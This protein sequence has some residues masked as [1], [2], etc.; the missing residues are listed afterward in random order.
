MRSLDHCLFT[1][2]VEELKVD[3]SFQV[4]TVWGLKVTIWGRTYIFS[5]KI[6]FLEES[7]LPVPLSGCPGTGRIVGVS[8]VLTYLHWWPLDKTLLL[9]SNPEFL[10]PLFELVCGEDGIMTCMLVHLYVFTSAAEKR[11]HA[12]LPGKISAISKVFFI[13]EKREN[14]FF[15]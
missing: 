13:M 12:L 2:L 4:R 1:S 3:T 11:G 10:N 14:N 7:L 15:L 8:E 6:R 5:F 9:A